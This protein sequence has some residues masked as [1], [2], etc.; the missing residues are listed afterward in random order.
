MS[1]SPSTCTGGD[2]PCTD[3]QVLD[4]VKKDIPM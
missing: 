3:L 4:P 2:E 1:P